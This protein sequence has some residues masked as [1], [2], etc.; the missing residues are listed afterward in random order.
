MSHETT[1]PPT[2]SAPANGRRRFFAGL[3]SGGLIGG[4][5]T[6]GVTAVSHGFGGPGGWGRRGGWGRHAPSPEALRQ[7]MEFAADW[8]LSRIG[9]SEE[10][11][12]QVK[13]ILAS[14]LQDLTPMR[15]Q[16]QQNRQAFVERLKQPSVDRSTL[17]QIRRAELALAESASTRIVQALADAAEALTAEQRT[18][19]IRLAE[20][21]RH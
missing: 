8:A 17:E 18:A 4:L 5:L 14:A 2:Q 13:A 15:E 10:Q 11:R 7:R 1:S 20:Q 19:L 16:H 6:T 3:I 9:A 21:F 12:Q